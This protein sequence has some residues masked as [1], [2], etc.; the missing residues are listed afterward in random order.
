[1]PFTDTG[2]FSLKKLPL[3]DNPLHSVC[4]F[5]FAKAPFQ[6]FFSLLVFSTRLQATIIFC[7]NVPDD[8]INPG[9]I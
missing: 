5:N 6:A 7:N 2:Q 4:A 1:M 9:I 8:Y 3:H